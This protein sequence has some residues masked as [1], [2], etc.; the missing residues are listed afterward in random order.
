[1]LGRSKEI[2]IFTAIN[3]S[4]KAED[5]IIDLLEDELIISGTIFP[6]V[7]LYYKWAGSINVDDE[8][9]LMI[10]ARE[11]NYEAI[12]EYIQTHHHYTA[13]EIV[14][15]DATFG[16]DKFKSFVKKKFQNQS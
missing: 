9:K 1:M 14:K 15:I 12:E 10:K 4:E 2:L 11:E 7:K 13:P 6:E 5:M 8:I 16:S 3:D